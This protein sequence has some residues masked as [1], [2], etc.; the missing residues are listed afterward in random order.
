MHKHPQPNP[1]KKHFFL[2]I[3]SSIYFALFWFKHTHTRI[4]ITATFNREKRTWSH[5]RQIQQN[6]HIFWSR[7]FGIAVLS[8][9][10]AFYLRGNDTKQSPSILGV[11]LQ[12]VIHTTVSY[13]VLQ[14]F[15]AIF[16]YFSDAELD[17]KLTWGSSFFWVYPL[18]Y[19]YI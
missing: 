15:R 14:W 1:P 10:V 8:V 4:Y 18:S 16:S 3:L 13:S 11:S 9:T 5:L 2:S 7:R 12:S 19:I 6:R 17:T